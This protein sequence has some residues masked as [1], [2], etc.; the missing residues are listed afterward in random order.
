[1]E[2]E[3]GAGFILGLLMGSLVG[4]AIA[5]LMT[6]T[7]GEEARKF[8]KEKAYDPAKSKVVDLAGEVKTKA[9]DL[10]EDLKVKAGDIAKDIKERAGEIWEKGKKAVTEK[11]DDLYEAFGKNPERKHFT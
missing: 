4:A 5:V 11:K 8:I 2:K 10:A 7:T 9:E 3:K 6:P 1:M